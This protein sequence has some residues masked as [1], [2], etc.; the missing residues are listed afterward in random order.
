MVQQ[1]ERESESWSL[2]YGGRSAH[3]MAYAR[4]LARFGDRVRIVP[5]DSAGQ[6]ETGARLFVHRNTLRYRLRLIE[7]LSGQELSTPAAQMRLWVAT[8]AWTWGPDAD[9]ESVLAWSV[10]DDQ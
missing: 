4:D 6:A 7:Q 1:A 8:T 9:A 5:E 2:F 10:G 3:S